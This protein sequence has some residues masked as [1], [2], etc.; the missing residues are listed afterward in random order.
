V[1]TEE[2]VRI[3]DDLRAGREDTIRTPASS[4]LRP[5]VERVAQPSED[6]DASGSVDLDSSMSIEHTTQPPSLNQDAAPPRY[7]RVIGDD[8]VTLI[9]SF[10]E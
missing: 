5:S 7:S 1:P 9:V 2:I 8:T 10:V 6:P 3:I 4:Q